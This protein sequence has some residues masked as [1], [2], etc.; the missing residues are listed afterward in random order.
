[1]TV[2][3]ISAMAVFVWLAKIARIPPLPMR[4][5]WAVALVATMLFALLACGLLLWKRTRFS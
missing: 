2:I 4:S 1:M 3:I 5:G